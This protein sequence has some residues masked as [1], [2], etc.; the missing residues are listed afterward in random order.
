MGEESPYSGKIDKDYS[1]K[2]LWRT[3]MGFPTAAMLSMSSL[4][5]GAARLPDDWDITMLDYHSPQGSRHAEVFVIPTHEPRGVV[6]FLPGWKTTA[7]DKMEAIEDIRASG[8]SVISVSLVNP[9]LETG[10][11]EDSLHRIKSF[12][13]SPDSPLFNMFP[14]RLPRF[15]VTH[16]TSGMLFQHALIDARFESERLPPITH[17]FHTAPFFDTSGSSALFHPHKNKLYTNH[18]RK[19]LNELAGTPFMDRLYYYFRGLSRLLYE[20]D[21]MVRPTHGQILEISEYGHSYFERKEQEII[22]GASAITIPQTFIISTDD[23]FS[24]PET[25]KKAAELEHA[26]IRLCEA[27]HNPLLVPPVRRSIIERLIDLTEPENLVNY[28]Q[29]R[30]DSF[31]EAYERG[32]AGVGHHLADDENGPFSRY[33]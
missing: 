2:N 12:A 18:A 33:T 19:H 7:I 21:P 16:S 5:G 27:Q 17:A 4:A 9:G 28:L 14:D 23:S 22:N 31:S 25:A 30:A 32:L 8:Y 3:V 24:C 15:L 11:L 26:E 6:G 1:L 13:F 10:T 29:N 20:E